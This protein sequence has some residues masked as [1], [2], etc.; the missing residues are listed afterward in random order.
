MCDN[1]AV[2]WSEYESSKRITAIET[3]DKILVALRELVALQQKSGYS[4]LYL[5]GIERAITRIEAFAVTPVPP[6]FEAED[7]TLF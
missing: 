2:S 1:M 7:P 5:R 3:R 4:E 6:V